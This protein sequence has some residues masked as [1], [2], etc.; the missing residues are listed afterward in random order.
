MARL[1]AWDSFGEKQPNMRTLAGA[2]TLQCEWDAVRT[3]NARNGAGALLPVGI[4]EVQ[5]QQIAG[6]IRQHRVQ[7]DDIAPLCVPPGQMTV[8]GRIV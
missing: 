1:G 3:A 7:A 8:D 6:F 4:I 5:C 2:G